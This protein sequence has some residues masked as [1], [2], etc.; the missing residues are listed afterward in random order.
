M[1]TAGRGESASHLLP[2]RASQ[3]AK[4]RRE[5]ACRRGFFIRNHGL[6]TGD[7][8]LSDKL[9]TLSRI[10]TFREK[11]QEDREMVRWLLPGFETVSSIPFLQVKEQHAAAVSISIQLPPDAETAASIETCDC[12][13]WSV[14]HE[15]G[16]LIQV[17]GGHAHRGRGPSALPH[18]HAEVFTR[19]L[20]NTGEKLQESVH[21]SG[22]HVRAAR[23]LPLLALRQLALRRGGRLVG[24]R[25][26]ARLCLGRRPV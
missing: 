7:H 26:P 6:K 24:F 18:S 15:P 8:D 19:R 20:Q 11:S 21:L 4:D 1:N 25:G 16:K 5:R 17:R 22:E 14:L 13:L 23:A 10:I 3:R 9:L 12:V 2:E